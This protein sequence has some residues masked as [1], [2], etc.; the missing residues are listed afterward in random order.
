MRFRNGKLVISQ[1]NMNRM[2]HGT[3]KPWEV[4]RLEGCT[5]V[6]DSGTMSR[7]PAGQKPS[8]R[9]VGV[10]VPQPD[11]TEVFC[12]SSWNRRFVVPIAASG[13]KFRVKGVTIQGI[14][15]IIAEEREIKRSHKFGG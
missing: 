2:F 9:V 6:Q 3:H 8:A 13:E 4:L 10:M 7:V 12:S 14:T 11:G 15:P 5:L 1:R